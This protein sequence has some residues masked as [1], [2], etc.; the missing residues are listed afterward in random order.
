MPLVNLGVPKE[1]GLQLYIRDD[2][3]FTIR[4]ILIEL[5]FYVEKAGDEIYKGWFMMYKLLKRFNGYKGVGAGMLTVSYSRDI[6]LDLFQQLAEE[7][8]PSKKGELKTS[9]L[10]EVFETNVFALDRKIKPKSSTDKIIIFL[11]VTMLLLA[12]GI[13]IKVAVSGGG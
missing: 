12:L 5:G 11:G 2:G 4:K 3:A 10:R 6:I 8:S 1:E 13:G 7:E 9:F